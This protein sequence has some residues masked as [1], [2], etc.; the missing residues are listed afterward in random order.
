MTTA[1]EEAGTA[2]RQWGRCMD[3]GRR[4]N[5]PGLLRCRDCAEQHDPDTPAPWR[6]LHADLTCRDCGEQRPEFHDQCW[7]CAKNDIKG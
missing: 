2:E 7:S 1:T 6:H 3:C 4:V 5:P